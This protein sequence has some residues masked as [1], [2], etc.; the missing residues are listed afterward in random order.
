M[1]V[2]RVASIISFDYL[3]CFFLF[4]FPPPPK[5]CNIN[6][7]SDQQKKQIKSATFSFVLSKRL[8]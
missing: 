7:Q 2:D 6:L 3:G 8:S 1:D 5:I 4:V